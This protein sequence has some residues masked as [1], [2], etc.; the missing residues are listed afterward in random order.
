MKRVHKIIIAVLLLTVL[1]AGGGILYVSHTL[2]KTLGAQKK[3]VTDLHQEAI[4]LSKEWTGLLET[5]CVRLDGETNGRAPTIAART[6]MAILE[7][8]VEDPASSMQDICDAFRSLCGLVNDCYVMKDQKDW[9]EETAAAYDAAQEIQGEI[10]SVMF[11]YN[12]AAEIYN[13]AIVGYE[14]GEIF[15]YRAVDLLYL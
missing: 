5:Y 7:K 3:E 15:G 8:T 11:Q 9:S 2:S 1:I 14:Y 12:H 10:Y 6:G 4:T 13:E